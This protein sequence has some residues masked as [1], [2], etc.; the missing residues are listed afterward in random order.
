MR[1][2]LRGCGSTTGVSGGDRPVASE[3]RAQ[4]A[5]AEAQAD[6]VDRNA[7]GCGNRRMSH[8]NCQ[9]F[10]SYFEERRERVSK[11]DSADFA[12]HL[13]ICGDCSRWLASQNRVRTS[14]DLLRQSVPS[15]PATLDGAM[16][17]SYRKRMAEPEA[18]DGVGVWR[19]MSPASLRIGLA[20]AAMLLIAATIFVLRRPTVTSENK[21]QVQLP[22]RVAT[23]VVEAKA[24]VPNHQNSDVV[25]KAHASRRNPPTTDQSVAI[26]ASGSD[27]TSVPDG[28]RSLMYCDE[29]ICDGGKE[30]VRVEF[31]PMGLNTASSSPS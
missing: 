7:S 31:S 22:P 5:R 4:L 21:P 2:F 11:N 18:T 19:K 6:E 10:H 25:R 9:Q 14:L 27:H 13:A 3:S 28:F 30:V 23:P 24:P 12:E 17:A 1:T 20:V 8:M 26:A 15:V 16:L 29:L